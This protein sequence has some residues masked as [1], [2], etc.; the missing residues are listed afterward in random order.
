MKKTTQKLMFILT[1]AGSMLFT[2]CAKDGAIGPKGADGA[3]GTNGTNG[4]DGNANVVGKTVTVSPNSWIF[5]NGD[6]YTLY[7]YEAITQEVVDRGA[8]FIYLEATNGVWQQL[9]YTYYFSETGS[10]SFI[11]L[12]KLGQVGIIMTRSDLLQPD[13]PELKFKIVVMAAAAFKLNGDVDYSN[14][15][16]VK[17]RFG[18]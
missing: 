12:H 10:Y 14:Y 2:S 7:Y 3:N 6:Y 11:A 8:V 17:N 1:L 18:L 15:D 5:D 16:E 9:P 13:L 4:Q